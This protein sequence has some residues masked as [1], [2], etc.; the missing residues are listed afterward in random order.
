MMTTRSQTKAQQQKQ[1]PQIQTNKMN[2]F[3]I[4]IKSK[5]NTINGGDSFCS[6]KCKIQYIA[7]MYDYLLLS[8]TK[9][10]I[11]HPHFAKFRAILLEKCHEFKTDVF[12]IIEREEMDAPFSLIATKTTEYDGLLN[13]LTKMKSF[14]EEHDDGHSPKPVS[15]KFKILPRRSARLMAKTQTQATAASL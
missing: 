10:V 13:N 9:Q 3:N 7:E 15:I 5:L 1:Q 6:N 2:Q 8:E 12:H 4:V 11:L 14:L